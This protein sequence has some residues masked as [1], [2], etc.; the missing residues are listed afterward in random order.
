MN[1]IIINHLIAGATRQTWNSRRRRQHWTWGQFS[2]EEAVWWVMYTLDDKTVNVSF[3]STWIFQFLL[4]QG[5]I[6]PKG[7]AGAAGPPGPPGPPG[8]VV[9]TATCQQPHDIYWSTIHWKQNTHIALVTRCTLNVHT[10][11]MTAKL[12]SNHCN[13]P[14]WFMLVNTG[15]AATDEWTQVIKS[16]TQTPPFL[17]LLSQNPPASTTLL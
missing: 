16:S 14:Q 1:V 12:R 11:S 2:N 13:P 15:A 5:A 8:P 3:V 7:A 10:H 9:G 6:G 4:T 17:S